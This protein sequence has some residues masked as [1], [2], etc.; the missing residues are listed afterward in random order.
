MDFTAIDPQLLSAGLAG[1][2][3]TLAGFA[4]W[5]LGRKRGAM[6]VAILQAIGR[7]FTAQSQLGDASKFVTR[8]E[9]DSLRAGFEQK[10]EDLCGAFNKDFDRLTKETRAQREQAEK[11]TKE[12]S[13]HLQKLAVEVSKT[14]QTVMESIKTQ[15]EVFKGVKE[16]SANQ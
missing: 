14:P 9:F 5:A 6:A 10:L 1:G 3:L 8:E 16:L 12:L 11:N 7:I 2:G 13:D 15:L 4:T